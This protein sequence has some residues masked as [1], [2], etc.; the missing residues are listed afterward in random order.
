MNGCVYVGV[1]VPNSNCY[2]SSLAAIGVFSISIGSNE[3]LEI[4]RLPVNSCFKA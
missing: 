4:V 3:R 2:I 1:A